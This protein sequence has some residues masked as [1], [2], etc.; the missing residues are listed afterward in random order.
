MR[1]I[2][3]NPNVSRTEPT[4]R[5]RQAARASYLR[6]VERMTP[7]GDPSTGHLLQFHTHSGPRPAA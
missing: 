5:L 4:L 1:T 3:F 6:I 2:S 7:A